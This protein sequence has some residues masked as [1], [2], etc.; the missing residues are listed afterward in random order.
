MGSSWGE[1]PPQVVEHSMLCPNTQDELVDMSI[2]YRQKPLE[3]L[4]R[5]FLCLW[6]I[7]VENI[8][9]SGTEM[10][11]TASLTTHPSLKQRLQNACHASGNQTL[12]EWLTAAIR[13]VWPNQGD[14]PYFPSS[15]KTYA[16][17]QQVLWELGMK[18]SII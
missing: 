4:P 3:S 9:V 17:L 2:W 14:L 13:I 15:W 8:V 11:R 6:D 10:S 1:P 16:E 12:L 18:I 5:W 7:G